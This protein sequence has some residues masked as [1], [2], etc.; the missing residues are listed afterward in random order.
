MESYASW[1]QF[2]DRKLSK[3]KTRKERKTI[4][5]KKS[6][7]LLQKGKVTVSY[8]VAQVSIVST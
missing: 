2:G 4:K 8:Y 7:R 6:K 5:A 3:F 1:G